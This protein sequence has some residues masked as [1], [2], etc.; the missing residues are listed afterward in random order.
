[1]QSRYDRCSRAPLLLAVVATLAISGC[2]TVTNRERE[3]DLAAAGFVDRPANTA[4]RQTMLAKLP[5]HKFLRRVREDRV[6]YVYADPS[7]CNC[8]YVGTQKAYGRY[9][10]QQQRQKIAD[11]NALAASD[12]ANASWNWGAWGPFGGGWGAGWGWGPGLGW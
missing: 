10:R 3:S 9:Q 1:M 8:L 2:A 7:G 5:P 6:N 4:E 12:Y 11:E